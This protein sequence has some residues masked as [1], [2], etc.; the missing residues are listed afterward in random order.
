[1]LSDSLQDVR[2]PKPFTLVGM[3]FVDGNI[4]CT[5]VSAEVQSRSR[6][7]LIKAGVCQ[8]QS[9][10]PEKEKGRKKDFNTHTSTLR[11]QRPQLTNR[12]LLTSRITFHRAP[13]FKPQRLVKLERGLVTLESLGN[14]VPEGWVQRC[15]GGVA[16][17]EGT[18]ELSSRVN[19][20]PFRCC[21]IGR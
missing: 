13:T 21:C 17:D 14:T 11:P 6:V 12:I 16:G 9:F 10:F 19:Q 8:L 1:M 20:L 7:V 4:L 18:V 5:I 2:Q 3:C 15:R